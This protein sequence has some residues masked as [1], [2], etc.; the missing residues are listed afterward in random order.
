MSLDLHSF[1]TIT[2]I[3]QKE[4]REETTSVWLSRIMHQVSL[5]SIPLV[6]LTLQS[7]TFFSV[8]IAKMNLRITTTFRVWLTIQAEDLRQEAWWFYYYQTTLK[9]ERDS[10]VPSPPRSNRRL[11]SLAELLLLYI[12]SHFS[13]ELISY[14]SK[15]AK[16]WLSKIILCWLCHASLLAVMLFIIG[17]GHFLYRDSP[18]MVI[19]VPSLSKCA[20][21][22]WS[23][24][25]KS[26]KSLLRSIFIIASVV[27]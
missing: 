13:I 19:L 5:S 1:A 26:G 10:P 18:G 27:F 20:S 22:K 21:S 16:F 14:I 24:I 6:I 4:A 25:I 15:P 17:S 8:L 23:G 3:W 9:K 12:V 7:K 2:Y 11:C